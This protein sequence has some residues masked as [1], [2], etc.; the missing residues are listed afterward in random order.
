MAVAISVETYNSVFPYFYDWTNAVQDA[1]VNG[2]KD[3]TIALYLYGCL[4]DDDSWV[5]GTD[6]GWD[7][8]TACQNGTKLF[9]SMWSGYVRTH[10][11]ESN[12]SDGSAQ[13]FTDASPLATRHCTTASHTQS[14]HNSGTKATSPKRASR[15]QCRSASVTTRTLRCT[16]GHLGSRLASTITASDSR[17]MTHGANLLMVLSTWRLRSLRPP[18]LGLW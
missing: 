8:F 6:G 3:N 15:S 14:S 13:T 12:L 17:A 7:C 1:Y 10:A 5:E 2:F 16:Q 11:L 9:D 18:I 4:A